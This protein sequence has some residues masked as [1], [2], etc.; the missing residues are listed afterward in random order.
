M[1]V[2]VLIC[3]R[4]CCQQNKAVLIHRATRRGRRSHRC[5]VTLNRSTPPPGETMPR[6]LIRF[7]EDTGVFLCVIYCE[8]IMF[9]NSC[10]SDRMFTEW[11]QLSFS[12]LQDPRGRRSHGRPSGE[13]SV[14]GVSYLIQQQLEERVLILHRK[15]DVNH[16]WCVT[17][18]R[19]IWRVNYLQ[20]PVT[21]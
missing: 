16:S 3:W 1:F 19:W 14:I 11:V 2:C 17:E 10:P 5:S 4:L 15:T 13:G 20:F 18:I 8:F 9:I 21:W 7:S 6:P 12:S